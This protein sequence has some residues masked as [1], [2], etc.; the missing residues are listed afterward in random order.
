MTLE[1]IRAAAAR[2]EGV[3]LQTPLLPFPDLSEEL[4]GEIRLKC[5]SLQRAGSFKMRGAYNF[6]SQMAEEDLN[7]GVITYSS[8]NHAQ[9][10]AFAAGLKGIRAVVVMPTT[11]TGVKIEGAKRL[12]AE[13]VLEGTTSEH[14]KTR[15]MV[16][17]EDEGLTLV[18]P[19]DHPFIIAG[20]GSVGLEIAAEWP[21]VET[22]LVPIGG[23]GLAS[24]TAA[25]L[26]GL[27]PRAQVMGVEAR[28]APTMHA[29]LGAGEPVTLDSTDTIA[30]GLKP[31]RAG[32]LTF[33]HARAL[34]DD[35][36]LVEDDAIREATALLFSRGK[37]VVEYSGAVGVGALLSDASLA[38][39]RKVAVI[40]SG[41][42]MDTSVLET[43]EGPTV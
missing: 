6:L 22:V 43:L 31:V 40:L 23:G 27:L 39:G 41:G 28:G 16:I 42:N 21:E 7:R 3:A 29:A 13:V 25:A 8:G 24:G 4:G 34:L 15:A 20:Q 1:E 5:E 26:K 14:R 35:V 9:A 2:I 11:A 12:G 37:I 33:L 17:A 19:F 32:D 38:H 18:P 10:V 30:D 36:V